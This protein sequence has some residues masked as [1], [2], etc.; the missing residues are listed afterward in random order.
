M[1]F[2]KIEEMIY[3][4]GSALCTIYSMQ[5]RYIEQNW[6][7]Q[8]VGIIF[9]TIEASQLLGQS[10]KNSILTANFFKKN[11]ETVNNEWF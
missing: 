11:I 3:W 7:H 9:F 2:W 10:K 8:I 6:T 4:T 1:L 5:P